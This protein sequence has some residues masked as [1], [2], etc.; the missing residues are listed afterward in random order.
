MRKATKKF[1]RMCL[2]KKKNVTLA[3][4][5]TIAKIVTDQSTIYIDLQRGKN[6]FLRPKCF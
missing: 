5:I 3:W 1:I 4:E 2:M 6:S